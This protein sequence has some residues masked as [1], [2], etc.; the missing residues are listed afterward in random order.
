MLNIHDRL[1]DALSSLRVQFQPICEIANG[2]ARLHALEAQWRGPEG[3]L[4]AS[5]DV[6]ERAVQSH[7]LECFADRSGVVAAMR[8]A[9]R[10]PGTP[11]FC[12]TVH[13]QT[14]EC[15][16]AFAFFLLEQAYRAGITPSRLTVAVV[17]YASL[18]VGLNFIDALRTLR[19]LGLRLAIERT[20]GA[21]DDFDQLLANRPDFV[22]VDAA[23]VQGCVLDDA[24]AAALARVTQQARRAG[25]AVVARG[26][27]TRT[28]LQALRDQHIGLVQG[29][30]ISQPLAACE[31]ATNPLVAGEAV[32]LAA[33]L[34]GRKPD[35][36]DHP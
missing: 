14:L 15:D 2:A 23:L 19:D 34:D 11:S 18:A 21:D 28:E 20:P 31:L 8:E 6:L 9:A 1:R 16:D 22:G 25:A 26:V 10:A 24:Q 13:A 36:G 33:A 5:A 17:E 27:A 7:R 30:L 12:V 4:F 29:D 32:P 3:S 35:R